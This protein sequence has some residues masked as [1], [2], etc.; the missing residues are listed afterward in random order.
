MAQTKLD[1][2]LPT[3]PKGKQ[4]PKKII[5][6]LAHLVAI[7][8]SKRLQPDLHDEVLKIIK[9]YPEGSLDYVYTNLDHIINKCQEKIK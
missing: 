8:E 1:M 2:N 4:P 9:K 5:K 6:N 7:L 3:A